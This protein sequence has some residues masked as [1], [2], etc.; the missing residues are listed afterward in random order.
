MQENIKSFSKLFVFIFLP[1]S[2]FSF[3]SAH[4]ELLEMSVTD[5]SKIQT[6]L[7]TE[8]YLVPDTKFKMGVYD[9]QTEKAYDKREVYQ[10]N[11]NL[12]ATKTVQTSKTDETDDESFFSG[13]I[14]KLQDLFSFVLQF[15]H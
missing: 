15:F 10:A 6:E 1:L 9:K 2:F 12:T 7:I 11:K 13:I 3:L 8:G 5:L 4:S 14:K